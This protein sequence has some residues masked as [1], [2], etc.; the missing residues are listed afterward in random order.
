MSGPSYGFRASNGVVLIT[1]KSGSKR[2]RIGV[3]INSNFVVDEAISF[4]D[5]Q[6]EYGIGS[7]SVKP[8]TLQKAQDYGDIAWGGKLDGSSVIQFD[9]VNRPYSYAGNAM[10]GQDF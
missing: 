6:T 4:T 10:S 8:V 9:G 3:E 1:T 5:W 2:K 7:R